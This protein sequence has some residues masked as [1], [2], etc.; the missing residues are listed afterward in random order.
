M[1]ELNS[2]SAALKWA[3]EGKLGYLCT[4]G[5]N[6]AFSRGLKRRGACSA[7]YGAV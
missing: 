2:L 1:E 6:E 4:S 3:R 5:R 7:G